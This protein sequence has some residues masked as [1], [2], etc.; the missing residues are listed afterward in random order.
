MA[1]KRNKLAPPVSLDEPVITIVLLQILPQAMNLFIG[2]R[3]ILKNQNN[4]FNDFYMERYRNPTIKIV[5]K[6]I[7]NYFIKN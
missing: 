3:N 2:N 1:Y 7:I 5:D 4:R 6:H